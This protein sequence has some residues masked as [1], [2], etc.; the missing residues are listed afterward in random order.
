MSRTAAGSECMGKKRYFVNSTKKLCKSFSRQ[1]A[2]IWLQ[3]LWRNAQSTIDWVRVSLRCVSAAPSSN[4]NWRLVSPNIVNTYDEDKQKSTRKTEREIYLMVLESSLN[5]V[6][7]GRR[8]YGVGSDSDTLDYYSTWVCRHLVRT[9]AVR[10]HVPNRVNTYCCSSNVYF[11]LSNAADIGGAALKPMAS[12]HFPFLFRDTWS[13]CNVDI[14][15]T[16]IMTFDGALVDL[17]ICLFLE[18]INGTNQWETNTEYSNKWLNECVPVG[19]E[20]R[21][22]NGGQVW[23]EYI[24]GNAAFRSCSIS[25]FVEYSSYAHFQA[26]NPIVANPTVATTIRHWRQ[27]IGCNAEIRQLLLLRIF[28]VT[29]T[30]Q[31]G[32]IGPLCHTNEKIAQRCQ[33]NECEQHK[34]SLRAHGRRILF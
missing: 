17:N 6:C 24:I 5:A 15:E 33:C 20:L 12:Y 10:D 29:D 30:N 27:W 4:I 22:R 26:A 1:N 23:N 18:A 32:H 25:H 28:I 7:V 9:L 31:T 2:R 14:S 3:L 16:I 21:G 34:H 8:D 19:C 13:N 11:E